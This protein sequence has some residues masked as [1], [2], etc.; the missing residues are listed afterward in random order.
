[1]FQIAEVESR[2][3]SHF[4]HFVSPHCSIQPKPS[5]ESHWR[6]FDFPSS[7]LD[8]RHLQQKLAIVWQPP[9]NQEIFDVLV[10]LPLVNSEFS[11]LNLFVQIRFSEDA[12]TKKSFS[13]KK[14]SDV[15]TGE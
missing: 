8:D 7:V 5:P 11:T 14:I 3:M 4:V 15:M 9:A 6:P 2:S 10:Q 13:W 1:M 12:R